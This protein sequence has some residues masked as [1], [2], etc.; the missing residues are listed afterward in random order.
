MGGSQHASGVPSTVHG[1]SHG[2]KTVHRTVFLT[3][4]RVRTPHTKKEDADWRSVIIFMNSSPQAYSLRS[5]IH[6]LSH[7]LKTVHRTVF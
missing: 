1:I 7:G 3:A 4:F 6:G 5:E 2:L